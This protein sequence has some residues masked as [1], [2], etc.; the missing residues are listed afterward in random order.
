MSAGA[1]DPSRSDGNANPRVRFFRRAMTAFKRAERDFH[2]EAPSY[3]PIGLILQ[4]LADACTPPGEGHDV[5]LDIQPRIKGPDDAE[6]SPDFS[7][8]LLPTWKNTESDTKQTPEDFLIWFWEVKSLDLDGSWFGSGGDQ[9]DTMTT[10]ARQCLKSYLRQL[11]QQ[12]L[13]A[14]HQFKGDTVPGFL[15]Q[16]NFFT[17]LLYHRPPNW[18]TL[19]VKYADTLKRGPRQS[20]ATGTPAP[21]NSNASTSQGQGESSGSQGREIAAGQ[22]EVPAAQEHA[23]NAAG[24]A[25]DQDAGMPGRD[26]NSDTDGHGPT[27]VAHSADAHPSTSTESTEPSFEDGDYPIPSLFCSCENILVPDGSG[28][29]LQFLKAQRIAMAFSGVTFNPS[30]RIFCLPDGLELDDIAITQSLATAQEAIDDFKEEQEASKNPEQSCTATSMA[31]SHAQYKNSRYA[32]IP[33]SD[34][35][36]WNLRHGGQI[37]YKPL[38]YKIINRESP[39]RRQPAKK[40]G[41]KRAKSSKKARLDQFQ[42]APTVYA[43]V[44]AVAGPSNQRHAPLRLPPKSRTRGAGSSKKRKLDQVQD[45]QVAPVPANEGAGPSKKRGRAARGQPAQSAA[46]GASPSKKRRFESSR[47]SPEADAYADDAAAGPAAGSAAG[48]SNEQVTGRSGEASTRNAKKS[49]QTSRKGKERVH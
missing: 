38:E 32:I 22:Q 47:D 40:P 11:S 16:G 23:D 4:E 44:N 2:R 41:P 29:S 49:G 25:A 46:Q 10:Q 30:D 9:F 5:F 42:D 21:G 6:C 36:L 27:S 15:S 43:H 24:S 18:D 7:A 45:D 26:R 34:G 33:P 3:T 8:M 13:F 31:S 1:P 20:T 12:A 48:P 35:K 19:S 37:M 39:A 14:F 28:F 17:L